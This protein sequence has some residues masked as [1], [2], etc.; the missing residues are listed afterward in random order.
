[1]EKIQKP[2]GW[3][4]LTLEQ[5]GYI[6]KLGGQ[7]WQQAIKHLDLRKHA[8]ELAV[9]AVGPQHASELPAPTADKIEQV[10]ERLLAWLE[11]EKPV[12]DPPSMGLG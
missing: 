7:M 10:A 5:R 1:M 3:D 9:A 2:E 8:L 4:K 6:M 12:D 11:K